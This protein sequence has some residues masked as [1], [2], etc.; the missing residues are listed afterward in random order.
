M[1]R[2]ILREPCMKYIPST[3]WVQNTDPAGWVAL[4]KSFGPE[5]PHGPSAQSRSDRLLEP[6]GSTSQTVL[7]CVFSGAGFQTR[8]F[9][10]GRKASSRHPER[11]RFFPNLRWSHA[12]TYDTTTRM[13]RRKKG[14]NSEVIGLS[15]EPR[16]S[17]PLGW[18][19]V[20]QDSCDQ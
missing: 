7:G 10:W 15:F 9:G 18:V 8:L 19:V 17:E 14:P 5:P 4:I 1:R 13:K 11:S 2:G 16:M 3:K 20:G 12:D 6:F